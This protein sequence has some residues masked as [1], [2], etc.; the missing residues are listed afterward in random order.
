[1]VNLLLVGIG[2]VVRLANTLGNDLGI[3]FLV[4]S[5]LAVGTLHTG[6]V[7]EEVSAEGAAHDV[8]ELLRNKFVALLLMNFLFLL[9][10]GTLTIETDIKGPSILQLFGCKIVSFARTDTKSGV[11][12]DSYQNSLSN[13]SCPLAP[14]QT[15]SRP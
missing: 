13:G 2:L 3:A 6:S 1:M 4:A 7:L 15:R 8:I 9:T 14:R 5:V 12:G 10:D 11:I